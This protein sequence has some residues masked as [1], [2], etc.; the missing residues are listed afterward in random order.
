MSSA[1]TTVVKQVLALSVMAE[2]YEDTWVQA[3]AWWLAGHAWAV[4]LW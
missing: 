3:C 4:S 1:R 2:K